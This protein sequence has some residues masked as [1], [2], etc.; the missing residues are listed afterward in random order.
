M[1]RI[2]TNTYKG[3]K[4]LQINDCEY[5]TEIKDITNT[6]D[7]QDLQYLEIRGCPNLTSIMIS[8]G[9]GSLT[10][11][12]CYNL[13]N[14][15]D[16]NDLHFLKIN[17]CNNLLNIPNS[18]KLISL[19]IDNCIN[20]TSIKPISQLKTLWLHNCNNLIEIPPFHNELESMP[21]RNIDYINIYNCIHFENIPIDRTETIK[22][23]H[24]KL[25]LR[26]LRIKF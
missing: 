23:K 2:C 22:I 26:N 19:F 21:R 8:R 5:I 11:D 13:T 18:Y 4:I 16:N 25:K 7:G 24:V 9:L 6:I 15:V 17:N 1:C 14:I 12:S 3:L 20:I 10:I